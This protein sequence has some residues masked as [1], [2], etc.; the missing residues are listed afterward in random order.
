MLSVRLTFDPDHDEGVFA[1]VPD[2]PAVFVLRGHEV[3][4]EPYVSKT[5]NLRRR[6]VRLLSKSDERSK[7]L[8]LRNRVATI[9][10]SPSGSDFESGFLLYKTL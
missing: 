10:Y 3:K 5:A 1:S 9:E 2:A 4:A 6:L 8:N 7:R